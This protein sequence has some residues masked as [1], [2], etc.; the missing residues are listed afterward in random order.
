[1]RKHI[2]EMFHAANVA[3]TDDQREA[4]NQ[5]IA[6]VTVAYYRLADAL[7][8]V[9]IPSVADDPQKDYAHKKLKALDELISEAPMM[10]KD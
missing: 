10:T 8:G 7:L 5:W 1:M 6:E 2:Q 9:G 3:F 4:Y